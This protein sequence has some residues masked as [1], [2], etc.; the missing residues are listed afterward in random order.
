MKDL[1]ITVG[2]LLLPP[3]GEQLLDED[4]AV[5][6]IGRAMA[7]CISCEP[8]PFGGKQGIADMVT[9]GPPIL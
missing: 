8:T 2:C 7:T 3:D 1:V 6:T 5:L 9:C 4:A